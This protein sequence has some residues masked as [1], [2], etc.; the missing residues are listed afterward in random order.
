MVKQETKHEE[1]WILAARHLGA[2][3]LRL[4]RTDRRRIPAP[5]PSPAM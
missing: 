1:L 2:F 3:G 4:Q 5:A